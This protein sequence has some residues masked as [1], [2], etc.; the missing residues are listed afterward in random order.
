MSSFFKTIL[1][2]NMKHNLTTVLYENHSD[3]VED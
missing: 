3:L 1:K 2:F